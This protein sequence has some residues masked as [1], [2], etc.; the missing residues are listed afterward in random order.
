MLRIPEY[1]ADENITKI[2]ME[3]NVNFIVVEGISDT[4]IY[5]SVI[6]SILPEESIGFWEV[7][8]V[9]N[10][11][12]IKALISELVWH[13]YICV[14]DRDFDETIESDRVVNLSRYSIENYLICE[15]AISATLAIT[16]KKRR[17]DVLEVFELDDFYDEVDNS[18]KKLLQAL[19][20]YHREISPKL[21]SQK[22]AWSKCS[23]NKNSHEWGLCNNKINNLISMLVPAGVSHE[24]VRMYFDEHFVPS[25][26][27][28]HDLPGKMLKL[29]LQKYI[30]NFYK[31]QKNKGGVQYRH[32]DSC[33]ESIAANLNHSK[34]FTEQMLPV[35]DFLRSNK[36]V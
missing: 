12:N 14:A 31:N 3:K 26:I 8:H 21:G 22:V 20:Y 6:R 19:F 10:K 2:Q 30:L 33:M 27:T 11:S 15:E 24:V 29:L 16:L 23:I 9:G 1:T 17:Q 7:V 18:A 36:V 4:P 32:V 34:A 28:A 5:E 13:N 35:L 25:E